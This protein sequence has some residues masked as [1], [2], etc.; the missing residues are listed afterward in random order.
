MPCD[1]LTSTATRMQIDYPNPL[2]PFLK[3]HQAHDMIEDRARPRRDSEV[4]EVAWWRM[5]RRRPANGKRS[6]MVRRLA[7]ATYETDGACLI[8]ESVCQGPN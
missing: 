6:R 3:F 4:G 2:N 8:V 1:F 5:H 7:I